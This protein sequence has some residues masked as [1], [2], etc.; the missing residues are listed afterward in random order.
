MRLSVRC[1]HAGCL[2]VCSL[3]IPVGPPLGLGK[4]DARAWREVVERLP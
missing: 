3:L 1:I 4:R 2:R